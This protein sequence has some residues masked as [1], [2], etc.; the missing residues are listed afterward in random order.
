[1]Q[2]ARWPGW[3]EA[4]LAQL[5]D[6]ALSQYQREKL[7]KQ[8]SQII[9]CIGYGLPDET[10]ATVNTDHRTTLITSGFNQIHAGE[11]HIYQVP[12]PAELRSQADEFDIRIEVTLSYV[13]QP[14]R[15]RRNLRRY[16]STWVDWKGSRLGEGLASFRASKFYR[17]D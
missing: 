7:L 8:A 10:R 4:I 13:A 6:P 1:M 12:I 2:S 3:A 17:I 14:R 11:C 9:R 16:L 15:T 5:R